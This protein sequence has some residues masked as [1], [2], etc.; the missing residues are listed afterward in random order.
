MKIYLTLGWAIANSHAGS[1]A[2][3]TV[4]YTLLRAILRHKALR[5]HLAASLPSLRQAS[6][7]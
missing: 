3:L 4:A 7:R 1:Y 6:E 2:L 5:H